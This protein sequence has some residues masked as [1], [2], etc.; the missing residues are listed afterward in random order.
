MTGS[1]E[2]FVR[3]IAIFWQR[4]SDPTRMTDWDEERC[5]RLMPAF[6]AAWVA[7]KVAEETCDRLA[8]HYHAHPT[9]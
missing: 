2:E 7:Y 3:M 5:K 4:K 9:R 8:D 6:H 1:D